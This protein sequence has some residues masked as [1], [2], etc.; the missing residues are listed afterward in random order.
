ML[1]SENRTMPDLHCV[2]INMNIVWNL[3]SFS[4]EVNYNTEFDEGMVLLRVGKM[5]LQDLE[6]LRKLIEVTGHYGSIAS[7]YKYDYKYR[8]D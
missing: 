3:Y 8:K 2:F 4:E 7:M 1:L 6:A 5:G